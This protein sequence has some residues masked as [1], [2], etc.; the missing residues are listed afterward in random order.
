MKFRNIIRNV[1][2]EQG[3]Y[4]ILLKTY[5]TPKKTGEKVKPAKMKVETLND[6]VKADPTTRLD[7]DEIKKAGSYTNWIIK[8]Y[9]SLQPEDIEY[10]SPQFERALKQKQE[11]FFEDLY[12]TTEDLKKFDRFKGLLPQEMRDI[13]SL[14]IK[15]LYEAVR[16]FSLEKTKA[17]KEEKKQAAT[18]Y[19]HPGADII[20][21]GNNWTVV[22]ISDTGELGRDAACF[23]GGNHLESIKGET[24]WCTSSPGYPAQ[25]KTHISKGPLYVVIPNKEMSF[26]KGEV[27]KGEYSGLPA[28][29]YQFHFP[30]NQ[31]MNPDDVQINLIDFLNENTELKEVFK[32]EFMSSI[33]G[34]NETEVSVEYPKDQ[35]SKFIALYGFDEFFDSLPSNLTRFDFINKTDD[36]L[37]V[38]IPTLI[39]KFQDLFILHLENIIEDLPKEIGKLKNLQFLSLPNNKKLKALPKEIAD[40]PNLNLLNLTGSNPNIKIPKELESEEFKDLTIFS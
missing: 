14:N 13:N 10:G 32:P 38:K 17:S 26:R 3:K 9:L 29:R 24:R 12:K 27:A 15:S 19:E 16:E 18:T 34:T 30:T 39:G 25:F 7:G 1:I 21:R 2:L 37:N 11:R 5:T 6:L 22:K 40:I 20:F 31:F 8:Q 33:I 36:N 23:Y 28:L 4:E 35:S